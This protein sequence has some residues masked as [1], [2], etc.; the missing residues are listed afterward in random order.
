MNQQADYTSRFID[1]DDWQLTD[2][3]FFF[4]MVVGGPIVLI[5]LPI[6]MIISSLNIFQGSGTPKLRALIFS[7]SLVE[8]RIA[9]WFLL[10]VLFPCFALYETPACRRYT[11]RTPLAF[12]SF[13]AFNYEQI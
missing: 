13:L 10:L 12:G 2:D 8:E 5:V 3:F 11:R 1:T 7:F 4:L 6:I 9:W